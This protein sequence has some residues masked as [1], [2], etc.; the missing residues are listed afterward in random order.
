MI[1]DAPGKL[2]PTLQ[3][4]LSEAIFSNGSACHRIIDDRACCME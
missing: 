2:V 4:F 3:N 1:D